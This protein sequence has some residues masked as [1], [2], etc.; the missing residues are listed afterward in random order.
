MIRLRKLS[1][2]YHAGDVL[3]P[4]LQDL[5]LDIDRGE[6]VSIIGASGSGKSTLMNLLGCLDRPTRGTYEFEGRDMGKLSDIQLARVRSR[7]I[8]FVFQSFNLLSRLPAIAQVELPLIYRGAHNRRKAAARALADV[9]LAGRMR[10]RPTQLSGGE[11]QRV[12]I[13]RALVTNPAL[14]LA[15]EP[16]GA[17]DT[18]TT[19]DVVDI[20]VRL[21]RERGMTVIFVTHEMDVAAYTHRMITLR[22][23]R[24]IADEPT[25]RKTVV[26]FPGTVP[27]AGA[28]EGTPS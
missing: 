10:H 26:P 22:D 24:I 3:V 5:D 15:D 11:Q 9:G 7:R 23:G 25:A 1:K 28:A 16:T 12:A 4:A 8:G 20:F 2:V 19:A 27:L 18:K 14:I 21:N 17:L 13:A 6:F